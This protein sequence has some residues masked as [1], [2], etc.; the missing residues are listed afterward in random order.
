MKNNSI[1][2]FFSV[3]VC[4]G[5]VYAPRFQQMQIAALLQPK[6]LER[7][8]TARK[9]KRWAQKSSAV[10]K[11]NMQ[12]SR[13]QTSCREP[14]SNQLAHDSLFTVF[15]LPHALKETLIFNFINPQEIS[16]EMHFPECM[17]FNS[18]KSPKKVFLENRVRNHI[19]ES[20]SSI[21]FLHKPILKNFE[22][23]SL[24]IDHMY[25]VS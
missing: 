10:S 22:M 14:L 24:Y 3:Q 11:E 23:S 17:P 2:H 9:K 1:N 16:P 20:K 7:M 25:F 5:G 6:G 18:K 8:V 21:F 19:P 13:G 4:E 12:I 15:G